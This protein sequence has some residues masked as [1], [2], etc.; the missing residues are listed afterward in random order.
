MP[1][2]QLAPL[3]AFALGCGL[4]VQS[5]C[6]DACQRQADC[7]LSFS[8]GQEPPANDEEVEICK[9]TCD[10]TQ[11][12]ADLDVEQGRR[13]RECVDRTTELNNCIVGL[14]CSALRA[15]DL[16]GNC[17]EEAEDRRDACN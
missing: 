14:E 8:R 12:R 4:S 17:R 5:T 2:I 3:F 6:E 10:A 15:S 13:S 11:L 7:N 9:A 1:E 16:D